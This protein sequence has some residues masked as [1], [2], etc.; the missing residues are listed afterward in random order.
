MRALTTLPFCA[1]VPLKTV[2]ERVKYVRAARKGLAVSKGNRSS[3]DTLACRKR[4]YGAFFFGRS[5]FSLGEKIPVTCPS[6]DPNLQ[7]FAFAPT[8][9]PFK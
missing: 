8:V 4:R 7:F 1:M 6:N 2:R 5:F 9:S 3:H